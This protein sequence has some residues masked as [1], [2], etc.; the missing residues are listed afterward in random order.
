M[1]DDEESII[2]KDGIDEKTNVETNVEGNIESSVET[3]VKTDVKTSVEGKPVKKSKVK[4]VPPR[5][6]KS[7]KDKESPIVKAIRLVVETGKVSFGY[8]S[9]LRV[10]KQGEVKLVI[11]SDNIPVVNLGEV[12]FAAKEANTLVYAFPG[13][14]KDLASICGKPFLIS[15]LSIIDI[16]NSNILKLIEDDKN[17]KKSN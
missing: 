3:D 10:V 16:G 15:V 14:S 5:R 11:H 9:V 7:K 8:N 1:S 4:K 2:N 17:D 12:N 13:S 6:R